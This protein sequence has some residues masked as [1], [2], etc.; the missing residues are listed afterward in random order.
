MNGKVL[1]VVVDTLPEPLPPKGTM[2]ARPA[3]GG[4]ASGF[5]KAS[6]ATCGRR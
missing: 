6:H 4:G 2:L 5:G 1:N 3:F